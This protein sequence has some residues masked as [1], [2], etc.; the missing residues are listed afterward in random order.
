ML[1]LL[2]LMFLGML[3]FFQ[4]FGEFVERALALWAGKKTGDR[5]IPE[6]G[7]RRD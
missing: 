6:E 7:E 1:L 5:R 4:Q 3:N 2:G